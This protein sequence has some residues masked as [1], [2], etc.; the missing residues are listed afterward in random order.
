MEINGKQIPPRVEKAC[1]NSKTQQ[2][3]LQND[4]NVSGSKCFSSKA[5]QDRAGDVQ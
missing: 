3:C 5:E 1:P 2:Y 4:C